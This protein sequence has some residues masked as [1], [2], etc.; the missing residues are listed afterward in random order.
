MKIYELFKQKRPVLSFEVF[1]PKPSLSF[2][3]VFESVSTLASYKPDYVSV[4]YGAA[5]S[6][7]G[8]T[9]DLAQMIKI[10]YGV[11]A[12]AHT[13]GVLLDEVQLDKLL[14]EID[15]RGLDNIL[16]LRGDVPQGGSDADLK[17]HAS[18]IV[19]LIRK[20]EGRFCIGVAAFPECHPQSK[21]VEDDLKYL[22]QKLDTG[23]DFMVTQM[24]FDNELILR[25]RDRV[26]QLGITQPMTICIMPVFAVGQIAHIS[27]MCGA[28]IP[29]E[30]KQTME[31]YS[32][33][34]ASMLKAGIEFASK[35]ITDLIA[36]D[37]EGIHIY[38]MNRPELAHGILVQTG[39]RNL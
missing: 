21:S 1:P 14:D 36:Q 19:R 26:R 6:T 33:D 27:S 18:D 20:R 9:L 30:L 32:D 37:F 38:T 39:L 35:Q 31:K 29:D 13:T 25:F 11:E 12:L 7:R 17:F 4:T 24:C 23:A 5:G 8:R 28:V 10:K 3:S 16:A 2:D 34:S 15:I 22:K